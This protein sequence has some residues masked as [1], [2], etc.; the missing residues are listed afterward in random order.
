MF[1]LCML[2]LELEKC[3]HKKYRALGTV[4]DKN[5]QWNS[6][7]CMYAFALFWFDCEDAPYEHLTVW[8]VDGKDETYFGERG[9]WSMEI[10]TNFVVLPFWK[11]FAPSDILEIG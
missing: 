2:A 8:K 7:F 9:I 6:Q 5:G 11:F 10:L 3:I 4:R 1:R